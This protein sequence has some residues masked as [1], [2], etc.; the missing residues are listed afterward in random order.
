MN[1]AAPFKVTQEKELVWVDAYKPEGR[2][3][4]YEQFLVTLWLLVTFIPVPGATPIRYALVAC[5]MGGLVLY[6]SD[7][8]PLLVKCWPLLLLPIWGLMSI[9]WTPYPS[10]AMRNGVLFLLTPIVL[11]VIAARLSPKEILRC[12]LFAGMIGSVLSLQYWGHYADDTPMGSKNYFAQ[13]MLFVLMLATMTALNHKEHAVIRALAVPFIALTMLQVV[14]ANSATALVFAIL[15]VFSLVLIRVFWVGL[16][17]IRHARS[18]IIL[19][20]VSVIVVGILIFL[21]MPQNTYY[22]DFLEALGKDSTLTG[23]TQI[24]AAGRVVAEDNPIIGVGLEGFW[25]YDVGAAQSINFYDHRAPG[26]RH[27]FHNA[28][29]ETRVHLGIIGMALYILIVGWCMYRA[30]RHWMENS[31]LVPAALLILATIVFVSTFTESTAW[32]TFNTPVNMLYLA[33]I[34]GF[35]PT[36]RRYLGK[37]P[38]FIQVNDNGETSVVQAPNT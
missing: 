11:F 27:S 31:D 17:G 12:M 34:A 18:M 19:L 1:V 22:R 28:Y 24:W 6:K 13:Q 25:Q 3:Q 30:V 38:A 36:G 10:L 26:T 33:G 29:L 35:S 16:A 7:V 23:R 15:G 37:V 8:L 2:A 20:G 5:F 32:A 21:S 14:M 9:G 4:L